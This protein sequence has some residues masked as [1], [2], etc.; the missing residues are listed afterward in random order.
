MCTHHYL[1]SGIPVNYPEVD[2]CRVVAGNPFSRLVLIDV[3]GQLTLRPTLAN[4]CQ[5]C[6]YVGVGGHNCLRP[7]DRL[8]TRYIYFPGR[9]GVCAVCGRVFRRLC[10]H[11][12]S[13]AKCR[14]AW[15]RQYWDNLIQDWDGIDDNL[16]VALVVRFGM[17]E[18]L[19]GHTCY[20]CGVVDATRYSLTSHWRVA[21]GDRCYGILLARLKDRMFGR[22]DMF[23]D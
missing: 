12:A 23:G 7:K 5:R 19:D 16:K 13:E 15:E 6:R 22:S 8:N 4:K 10:K 20:I 9:S 21:S 3:G 1:G 14:T 18:F 2:S 17:L 11:N